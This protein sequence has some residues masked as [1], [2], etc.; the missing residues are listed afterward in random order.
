MHRGHTRDRPKGTAHALPASILIHGDEIGVE[1]SLGVS[2]GVSLNLN[3]SLSLGLSLFR[4]LRWMAERLRQQQL[5]PL[6]SAAS[7]SR[8]RASPATLSRPSPTLFLRR[9]GAHRARV[10]RASQTHSS[11]HG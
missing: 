9:R 8:A 6:R 5:P 11:G 4:A 7:S 1:L 10:I 3:R 2:L